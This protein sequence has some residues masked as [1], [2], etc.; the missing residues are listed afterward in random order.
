MSDATA[1]QP[2]IKFTWLLGTFAA[3]ALFVV[4]GA[5]S[6]RMTYT[7]SDYNQ[8][9]AAQRY[10]TLK[11]VQ[12]AEN[13]LIYPVD[14]QG[15]P[16]AVWVDQG[17]GIIRIPID[18]AMTKELALLQAESPQPGCE[19]VGAAPAPAPATPAPAAP[20]PAM[21]APAQTNAAPAAAPPA[22]APA[23]PKEAKK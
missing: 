8:Q 10:V 12:D 1:P 18:E 15:K 11:K 21:T 2:Q 17:K 19:I 4:I 9:R 5:Y 13:A 23:K 20:A 3:F 22:A 16:T 6:S 7:Y 14:D